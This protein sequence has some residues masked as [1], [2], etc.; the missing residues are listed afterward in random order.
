LIYSCHIV[1]R[2]S[3]VHLCSH[4]TYG[5][6]NVR[7]TPAP[8]CAAI[9]GSLPWSTRFIPAASPTATVT[10]CDLGGILDHLDYLKPAPGEASQD[11]GTAHCRARR[12]RACDERFRRTAA[13]TVP[14]L[15][16]SAGAGRCALL[17][18]L[19]AG[20][21]ADGVG[22]E[23]TLSVPAPCPLTSPACAEPTAALSRS[24]G[25]TSAPSIRL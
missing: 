18:V 9:G 19:Q 7:Y 14:V 6:W 4:G 24:R 2:K 16:R 1:A 8:S 12:S 11:I 15:R 17:D 21:D 25:V 20:E 5:R 13:S 23:R 3:A 10:A 22:V